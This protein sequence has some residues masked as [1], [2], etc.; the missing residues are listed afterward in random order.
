MFRF[1][2]RSVNLS[3]YPAYALSK[4]RLDHTIDATLGSAQYNRMDID[5]GDARLM[6][7]PGPENDNDFPAWRA[8]YELQDLVLRYD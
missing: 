6:T 8:E 7:F 1:T 5:I 2:P 4:S 3:T